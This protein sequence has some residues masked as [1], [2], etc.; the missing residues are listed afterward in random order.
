MALCCNEVA[1]TIRWRYVAM[2]WFHVSV[3][4]LYVTMRRHYVS[5]RWHCITMIKL[6]VAVLS[7][8]YNYQDYNGK[9]LNPFMF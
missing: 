2:R 3:K 1:V 8:V 7:S 5:V 9:E 4:W 6:Y